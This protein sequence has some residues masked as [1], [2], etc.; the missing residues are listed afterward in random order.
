MMLITL[1]EDSSM[2]RLI[3]EMVEKDGK[4]W[5]DWYDNER[6][7]EIPLPCGLSDELNI[8]EQMLL[9][10]CL[11][12]DRITVALTRYVM[13]KMG[14]KYVMPPTLDYVV[15]YKQSTPVTPIVFVLSPGADPAF[16][17]FKL[18]EDMG[19]KP[20]AKL[21]Y[22]ALGQGMGP[23]A[24]EFLETGSTRGLWIM[25]QNCHLLPSWLK[26]LEK[27]LEKI[28]AS[29]PHKDF[30]LWLTTEP[31]DRF[32]LGILQ[33]S[34]KVVTEPPNGLK[35]NMRSSYSKIT[36][37]LLAECPHE[38]F[39]PLVYVLA[40]FHAVVQERRKY[41]K[42]GWNVPY[43]FN[44]TDFR[45]SMAL[46]STYLTKAFDN[47]DD[48]IPWG[49]LRYLIGEA[50]YGGRVSDNFDRRILTTYLDE[51]LGDFLF[52]TF[53]PFHFFSN[54][55][56]DYMVPEFGPR[57]N[58]VN[59]IGEL[60][61]V[62]TP[63]VF[64][65]HPNAD[66]SYYTL[67]TKAIWRD[68]VDLQPRT[69][70]AGGGMSREDRI[71]GVARDIQSKIPELFDIPVL[72]KEIA[73]PSPTQVVLLQEV[74]RWNMVLSKMRSSLR[75]LQRALSGEI[76]MSAEL[77]L[78]AS[79]LFNG[80]LPAMWARMNP[81]T[82]KMLGSWMLWFTRRYRQYRDWAEIG[83]PRVM[84]LSG[85]HIPETYLAGLVQAACREKGWPLDKSTLYT[86]VTRYQDPERISE[87]LKFGCYVQG[88]YLEG[89]AWCP[90]GCMLRRQDPK[91]L[92]QELPV[93]QIIPVEATKLKLSNVFKTPVY[94]T[95]GRAN[96]GGVGM[97]F[98]AD[99]A[100]NEH[101]SHW[102]LQGTALCL[103]VD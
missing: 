47:Q 97:V 100:T 52:D 62:Q 84:W 99:L 90:K 53:Q 6:P 28:E 17:V 16:D 22:M 96:A 63:E 82:D 61:M 45:I 103:N 86:A 7:E 13:N 33:R 1:G 9:M 54:R 11:R 64:G 46:I 5:K 77:D 55:E 75:D 81:S 92:V 101:P 91:L 88:L 2:L 85:L 70:G 89:A 31:T 68:L 29:N 35:L 39:R 21:K 4:P 41:G 24:Q 57:E 102:I 44:E 18:G 12:V 36:E 26:T 65:L 10:R 40:F 23:K 51:Y 49:T 38:A 80:G 27:L 20:G 98:I 66:V 69:G 94:V 42:L 73:I 59:T 30:R 56:V 25:L 48:M 78:L 74:E 83:E 15:I 14:E 93:L 58:Y 3:A 8:L 34:L 60:P 95:Q 37:E 19:F 32:P 79:S 67:G 71:G 72:R 43:D 50:M 87:K 76:G